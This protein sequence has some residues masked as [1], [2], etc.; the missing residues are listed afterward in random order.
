[1]SILTIAVR[2]TAG[3]VPSAYGGDAEQ[4]MTGYALG[5]GTVTD[6][7]GA[8][9]RQ[10]E[11]FVLLPEPALP[12]T[13]VDAHPVALV[14]VCVDGI[15]HEEVLCLR[16]GDDPRPLGDLTRLSGNAPLCEVLG[17]LH[18]GHT[19]MVLHAGDGDQAEAMLEHARGEFRSL[20]GA[21][22]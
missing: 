10:V 3:A 11:A 1:M 12:G 17:R 2:C 5:F 15:A 14:R 7:L 4:R 8:D 21:I 18:A 13:V 16:P 19:C 9:G 6:T 20:T 22:G